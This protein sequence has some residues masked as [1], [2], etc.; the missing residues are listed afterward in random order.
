MLPEYEILGIL[1]RGGMGAVYKAREANL[2]RIVA[3][4]LLPETF[5]QG[6]DELKFAA[7]FR[8]E[9]QSMAKFSHPAIVSVF[10]FG[11]TKKGQLYFVME[12]VDGMDIQQYLKEHG[13][14]LPQDSALTIIAHVLDALDYAHRHGIVHRD[15]KPANIL[16]NS[17]GQV[18]IADFGLAKPL[19]IDEEEETG[20]TMTAMA[21]GTPCFI[22]PEAFDAEQLPDHRADLYAVGVMLYRMLTGELP[23]GN[24]DSPSEMRAELDPRLDEA[25]E[26]AMYADPDTRYSSASELR[27][28]LDPVLISPTTLMQIEAEEEESKTAIKSVEKRRTKKGA[29]IGAVALIV[30]GGVGIVLM[31]REKNGA[32]VSESSGGDLSQDSRK[33]EPLGDKPPVKEKPAAI[34]APLKL[35]SSG[36]PDKP[37]PS[38][39]KADVAK[40]PETKKAEMKSPASVETKDSAGFLQANSN[41]KSKDGVEGAPESPLFNIPGF[42]DSFDKHFQVRSERV[43]SLSTQYLSRL[44]GSLSQAAD[45]GNLN[46]VT[47]FQKEKLAIEAIQ[48][49]LAV[50]PTDP[51]ATVAN[52]VGLPPLLEDASKEL[53]DLREIWTSNRQKIQTTFNSELRKSLN[54]L[55]SELGK[56]NDLA[57]AKKVEAY[58]NL[59]ISPSLPAPVKEN[60]LPQPLPLPVNP[61][62]PEIPI[63]HLQAFGFSDLSN[64]P[65]S[66]V[67][68][69]DDETGAKITGRGQ[70][71]G[72][73]YI[74]LENGGTYSW[75]QMPYDNG[76]V[77]VEGRLFEEDDAAWIFCLS[78]LVPGE[79]R[80][81]QI[82]VGNGGQVVCRS[83]MWDKAEKK[84]KPVRLHRLSSRKTE[85]FHTVGLLISDNTVEV[86]FDGEQIGEK[87]TFDF[88]LTPGGVTL[89]GSGVG[90]IEFERLRYWKKADN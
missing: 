66:V 77:E 30:F 23:R 70:A 35:A 39:A 19:M 36:K 54:D 45:I 10:D 83:S 31:N 33:T 65:P 85:D 5:T 37:K 52:K 18:K 42:K 32:L 29:L 90:R 61:D 80:G 72:K 27:L 74:N 7:R 67:R 76:V 4:K 13:E 89:G 46:L 73:F 71:D 21:V 51:V 6:D 22:A 59:L 2:D 25:I 47:A 41:S 82:S 11:E 3:I 79:N 63:A 69:Y 26:K 62:P 60:L 87:L 84:M 48:K 15:I 56:T 28:A 20:L 43:G 78:N 53:K 14:I 86:F 34:S 40:E 8:R 9:A 44:D 58:R 57:N 68:D 49:S 75:R 64:H 12:F 16:L 88:D 38:L 24:F 81:I 17:K 50:Y 55:E 1:G